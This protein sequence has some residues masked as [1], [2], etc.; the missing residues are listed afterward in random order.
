LGAL[1]L[2]WA[3]SASAETPLPEL[4]ARVTDTAGVLSPKVA[5]SLE[6]RLTRY[7]REPGHQFA[8]VSIPSLG[9]APIEDFSIR[10]A[11]KWHLGDKQRDDGLILLVAKS[12]RQMRIEVGYG[13][14]GAVPDA[15]AARIIRNQLRPA[16]RAGQFDQGVTQAF[17]LLMRAARGESVR[18]G[19]P[20]KSP[21]NWLS[22]D[23]LLRVAPFVLFIVLFLFSRWG[24]RGGGWLYY[25]GGY[26]RGGGGFSGGGFSGGGGG[27][28]GGGA[29]GGW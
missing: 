11:E 6:E 26:S 16:F 18:V 24:R 10:L 1:C 3:P 28:G 7:E 19:P 21:P 5:R 25:G 13:L 14:E 12:D 2:L 29:S 20:K 23:N 22:I 15:L 27:F 4:S 17:E 9:G 8:F